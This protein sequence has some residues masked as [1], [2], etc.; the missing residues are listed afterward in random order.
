MVVKIPVSLDSIT[1]QILTH[2]C[3]AMLL[4]SLAGIIVVATVYRVGSLLLV[5]SSF[6][7][8][9]TDVIKPVLAAITVALQTQHVLVVVGLAMDVSYLLQT[10]SN[11]PQATSDLS[12]PTCVETAVTVIMEIVLLIYVLYVQQD[13]P[14]V[15]Q[16]QLA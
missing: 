11:V 13:V 12:A 6:C 2:V 14:R 7:I 16:L 15:P 4:V 9:I 1:Q 10:V 5:C 8:Q 3:L